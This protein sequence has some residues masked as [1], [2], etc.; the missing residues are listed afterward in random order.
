[1]PKKDK[2]KPKKVNYR[3]EVKIETEAINDHLF[4]TAE[5]IRAE[6]DMFHHACE[7]VA[8]YELKTG[9]TSE[10][11][12]NVPHIMKMVEDEMNELKEAKDEAEQLD[13][14]LD[15]VYYLLT[16]AAKSRLDIRPMWKMIHMANMTK[17]EKGHKDPNGPKWIKPKDFCPPDDS[18]REEIKH[19][20]DHPDEIDTPLTFKD[21][22]TD[23]SD[24]S[25]E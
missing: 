6:N 9:N 16:E 12:F 8:L 10:P 18:I 19:Q 7:F 4:E 13:A 22:V 21:E 14:I 2:K 17:F 5:E 11:K 24:E 15:A 3:E 20:R 25:D 1:M 23:A